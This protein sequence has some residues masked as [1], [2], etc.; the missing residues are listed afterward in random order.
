ML[1]ADDLRAEDLGEQLQLGL[2]RRGR[3]RRDVVDGAVVLAQPD[4]PIGISEFTDRT[5]PSLL[6]ERGSENSSNMGGWN[7]TTA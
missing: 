1:F 7:E 4:R 2:T 6:L 3:A 5:D